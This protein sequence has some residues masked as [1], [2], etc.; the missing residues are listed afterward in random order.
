MNQ[1]DISTRYEVR[2]ISQL[3]EWDENPR[4]IS[5]ENYHRLKEQITRLGVY[6]PLLINQSNIVLGG[7]MRLRALKELGIEE[8]MCAI[9]LTDNKHQM[10]EYALSDNELMGTTDTD[11]LTELVTLNPV[12]AE[13]FAI[14]TGTLKPLQKV[15][16]NV[17]PDMKPKFKY[18]CPECGHENDASAFKIP[19]NEAL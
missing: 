4:N 9:V 15:I 16:D 11:K 17:S 13:L 2:K 10:I 7:N 19:A 18:Q 14:P 1:A 6:K 3:L 12:K 8:V 5:V